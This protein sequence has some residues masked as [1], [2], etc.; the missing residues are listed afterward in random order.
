MYHPQKNLGDG[1]IK[2]HYEVHKIQPISQFWLPWT[3]ICLKKIKIFL[4]DQGFSSNQ[5]DIVAVDG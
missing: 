3:S 1:N 4:T 2:M 5:V